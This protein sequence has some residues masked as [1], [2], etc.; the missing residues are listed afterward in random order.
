M[1]NLTMT[2]PAPSANLSDAELVKL[3]LKDSENF[4][5]LMQRYEAKLLRYIRRISNLNEDDAQ[6]ILQEVFIKVYNNLNNFDSSLKFSSWIYRIT[7]N[8]VISNFR[9]LKARPQKILWDDNEDFIKNIASE[10][11]LEK[12][13]DGKLDREIILQIL[14][15]LDFKYKEVLE[16]KF[17]E[18]KTY[19]EI[20]DILKKPAGSVATLIHRAKKEFSKKFPP[21][22][23]QPLAEKENNLEI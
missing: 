3:T 23:D 11:N 21:E 2:N 10:F 18:D 19:N 15:K 1:Y 8:S 9:K 6:D 13:I 17:L 7:H 20:S 14:D 4:L 22:A 16:L 5:Y 12:E